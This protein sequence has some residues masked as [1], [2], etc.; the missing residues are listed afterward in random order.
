MSDTSKPQFRR[1]LG[2][3]GL[4]LFGVTYMTI[5]VVFT[6]YGV[7]NQV[8]DGHLAAAYTLAIVAMLFTASSYAT[9]AR[10]YPVA[11]SAYTYTQQAFGGFAGFITG[12]V[13]LLDYLFIPMINFMVIGIYLHTQYPSVPEWV[14]TIAALLLVLVFNLLGI[15]FV[16][17]ANFAIIAL[18]VLLVLVFMLLVFKQVLGGDT[19]VGLLE[20]FSFGEGGIGAIASGAA[21]LSLSFLGFD[22]VSTLSEE[23]KNARRDIPR[24]I[25]ASTLVG[26]LLF[27]LVAWTGGL[28]YSPDWATLSTEDVDAAGV[29]LV[30]ELGG[31]PFTAFFIAVYVVSSFGSAMTGQASVSRLLFAMGRDGV[32]PRPLAKLH[33]RF[34]TPFIAVIVVSLLAMSSLVLDLNTAAFMI[35]FGALAAFA[36]VNLSVMKD[37][38]FSRQGRE[39]R[40]LRTVLVHLVCPL[41]AFG[42][43]VWLWT[44]LDPF[45][46]IVGGIWSLLGVV[47]IGI[48]T[49]GFRRPV[50]KLDFSGE[51]PT[52][53]QIDQLGETS[54]PR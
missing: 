42:L 40:T 20:P 39:R 22:A 47:I 21:I 25:F 13:I 31:A 4:T 50:P 12:W 16:N 34:G 27:V 3:V 52:T 17:R 28:A 15:S 11:G 8:T 43:T 2:P 5:A 51:S 45:T 36:M 24:A 23:A 48:V 30:G 41:I 44:S 10:K 35:S 29:T 19:S 14:F 7:V 1:T 37:L 46:W 6:T 49:R 9:L 18:S 32:L 54:A 38:F 53:T 33:P 26:G